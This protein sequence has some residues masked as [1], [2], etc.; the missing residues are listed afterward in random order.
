MLVRRYI[1]KDGVIM[2][3]IIVFNN[4]QDR[5]ETYSRTDRDP[6][7]YSRGTTLLVGEFR[8]SS[9][10]ETLWTSKATMDAWDTTRTTYARPI[11]VGYAFKRIWEGGHGTQSQHYAGTAFDVGQRLTQAERRTIYVVAQN[12]GV[13]GYVEPLNMTPTWVHFDRRRGTPAC[14]TG[15][16]TLRHG[17]ASNYVLVLQDALNAIGHSTNGLD[18]K[19]GNGT[20]NA[21]KSFQRGI[22][23]TADG[24]VGCRTWQRL[25][26]IAVGIGRTATV[27]D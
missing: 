20:Q 18:G 26:D 1:M 9:K 17:N 25:C 23:L 2:A 5:M 13:W 19:F 16:P 10:S 6:M 22:G 21:V 3:K 7:P 14:T 8:G 12:V 15:Y 24:I 4:A 27:I 11:P